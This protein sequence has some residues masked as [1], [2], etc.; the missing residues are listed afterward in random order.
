MKKSSEKPKASLGRLL[1]W[2]ITQNSH[3]MEEILFKI[4]CFERELSKSLLS[5]SIPFNGQ[6][7]CNIWQF[8]S[9]SKNYIH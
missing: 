6:E 2:W 3:C 8:F 9:Y 1:N 4:R 7:R 5:N